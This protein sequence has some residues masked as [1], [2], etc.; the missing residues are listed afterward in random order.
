MA[1]VKRVRKTSG[2][3]I[4][5]IEV[6]NLLGH[7]NYKLLPRDEGDSTPPTNLLL[8]YGDNGSGKTTIAHCC[9]N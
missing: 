9:P 6:E 3:A 8:L 2:F 1:K 7:Y 5:G 4:K